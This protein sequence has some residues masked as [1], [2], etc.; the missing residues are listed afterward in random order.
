MSLLVA[1][2]CLALSRTGAVRKS[3]RIKSRPLS[4]RLADVQGS[5][6]LLVVTAWRTGRCIDVSS[7]AHGAW[8]MH[9]HD[10]S[11][12]QEPPSVLDIRAFLETLRLRWWVIPLTV[13]TSL[14]IFWAQETDVSLEPSSYLVT[15]IFEAEDPTAVLAT[16]G[17]DRAAVR[18]FPDP[19]NQLNLLA[20]TVVKSEIEKETGLSGAVTVQ[21]SVPQLTLVD[22][23]QG[24][25]E[26]T[27]TFQATS[28]PTWT[29]KC[30]EEIRENCEILIDAYAEKL[31][32]IRASAIT[33]GLQ[34]LRNLLVSVNSSESDQSLR[35][36]IAAIDAISGESASALML[37]D[38]R[39][40]ALGPIVTSFR[41]PTYTFALGAGLLISLLIILQL[42]LADTRI[43]TVRQLV[44]TLP[45]SKYLGRIASKPDS[46]GDFGTAM[47][48]AGLCR[49]RGSETVKCYSIRDTGISP[50]V[51][52]RLAKPVEIGITFGGALMDL[53][54]DT[55]LNAQQNE[56]AVLLVRRNSDLRS[57]VLVTQEALERVLE[58][59][60]AGVVLIG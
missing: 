48:I 32:G 51:I 43:R 53:G 7:L 36:K 46:V 15:H 31:K 59:S 4:T 19:A 41:R 17:I 35:L 8:M 10:S 23:T 56:M 49:R 57:D 39:D 12:V 20:S 3:A 54:V 45:A 14:V 30:V 22:S 9:S 58:Q 5:V 1:E 50:N 2:S 33:A 25:G 55:I 60:F 26:G 38:A 18:Q 6:N 28:A 34:R 29:F 24:A 52:M 44:R 11:V 13:L 47:A 37:I 16:V 27:V 21:R 42:S 40:E